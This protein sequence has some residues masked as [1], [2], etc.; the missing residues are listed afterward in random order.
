MA[1]NTFLKAVIRSC[2]TAITKQSKYMDIYDLGIILDY[3][4]SLEPL[5]EATWSDL[6]MRTAVVF[7]IF[8]PL[9]PAAML[10]LDPSEEKV[11]KINRS[12][13]VLTCD[14]RD[15]KRTRTYIVIRPLEDKRLCPLKHYSVLK[16]EAR[17]RGLFD[18]LWGTEGG[19]QFKRSDP[20]LYRLSK[21]L[22]KARKA[23]QGTLYDTLL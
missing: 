16:R 12:I 19:R 3:L 9:R 11:S 2:A 15:S 20:I 21:F 5:E 14:K 7:M 1:E 23:S 10:R 8:I 18:C 17:K 13:E 4:R 6:M 22:R